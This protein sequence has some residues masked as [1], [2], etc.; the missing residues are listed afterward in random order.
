MTNCLGFCILKIQAPSW[1]LERDYMQLSEKLRILLDQHNINL[2]D[3]HKKIKEIFGNHSVAKTTLYR[4][5][6]G[7]TNI[8][9]SSLMQIAQALNI[10]VEEIKKDTEQ[11]ESYIRYDYNALAYY[12][13][14][15]SKLPFMAG[16]LVILPKGKTAIEQMPAE[17]GEFVRWIQGIKG[18]VSCI[19]MDKDKTIKQDVKYG[20]TFH[21]N[22]TIPHYFENT[23]KQKAICTLVEY[24]RHF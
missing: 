1:G 20:E 12:E 17:K 2:Q 9:E 23:T 13:T 6:N 3:L 10:T 24:P 19:I 7:L 18:T 22:S 15:N 5:L 4:T 11:Q 8:R 14:T 16:R 21:F